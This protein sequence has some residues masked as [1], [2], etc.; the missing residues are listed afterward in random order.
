MWWEDGPQE[1]IKWERM[2]NQRGLAGHQKEAGF[3]MGGVEFK[4][5]G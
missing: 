3:R 4:E 2:K 5:L 1:D